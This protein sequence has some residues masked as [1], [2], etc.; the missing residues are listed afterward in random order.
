MGTLIKP[1]TTTTT[2]TKGKNERNK[3]EHCTYC[4]IAGTSIKHNSKVHCRNKFHH[5][6]GLSPTV[7]YIADIIFDMFGRIPTNTVITIFITIE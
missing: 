7:Y 1:T 6:H 2:T 5:Y 4:T 3:V